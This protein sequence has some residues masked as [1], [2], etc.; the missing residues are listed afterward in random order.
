MGLIVSPNDDQ[1][2]NGSGTNASPWVIAVE[3]AGIAGLPSVINV[4]VL[5]SAFSAGNSDLYAASRTLYGLAVDNK[6]P[7]IFKKCTK[8]GLPL[9]SLV[10]TA[11]FGL[12]AY[13]NVSDSAATVFGWLSNLSAITGLITWSSILLYVS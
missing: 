8:N 5:I 10:L 12:L 2:L 11:A 6:A 9:W 1:L 3:R 4:V 13:M 7:A